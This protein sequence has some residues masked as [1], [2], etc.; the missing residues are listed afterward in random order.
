VQGFLKKCLLEA[1]TGHHVISGQIQRCLIS[2]SEYANC[3]RCYLLTVE[4]DCI[5]PTLWYEKSE[6][7][8]GRYSMDIN[9][10]LDREAGTSLS[11]ERPKISVPD[12]FSTVNLVEVEIPSAFTRNIRELFALPR[13]H[14]NWLHAKIYQ[15]RISNCKNRIRDLFAY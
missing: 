8:G 6:E 9:C 5:L 7:V 12:K 13:F 14:V 4:A 3:V 2:G 1:T 15:K 11:E 10:A